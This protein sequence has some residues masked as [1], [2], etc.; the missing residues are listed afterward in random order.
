[1]TDSTNWKKGTVETYN[2]GKVTEH[3]V[4]K[5]AFAKHVGMKDKIVLDYG[6]GPGEMAYG[7]SSVAKSV[8]GLDNS[9]AMISHAKDNFNSE[10][11][12]YGVVENNN[13]PLNDESVDVAVSSCVLMMMQDLKDID[14]I[15]REMTRVLKFGGTLA[16]L[17][18]HP[19]Y[20][21]EEFSMYRTFKFTDSSLRDGDSFKFSLRTADGLE[22]HDQDFVDY[23]H[24]LDDYISS[25]QDATGSAVRLSKVYS[26]ANS[27]FPD[28]RVDVPGY[29]LLSAA[30]SPEEKTPRLF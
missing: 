15:N 18:A 3:E 9:H 14:K 23:Y 27:C 19:E 20:I 2:V 28:A 16:H 5:E 1:M 6:C 30:K 13:I 25:M 12:H 7:W 21:G 8:I 24:S 26:P 17:L 4:F 22:H 29:V 10:N 11:L